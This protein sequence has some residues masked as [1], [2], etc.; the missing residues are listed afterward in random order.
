VTREKGSIV[1]GRQTSEPETPKAGNG[2][3]AVRPSDDQ[4]GIA[5]LYSA[6]RDLLAA[7]WRE[8]MYA[9]K[10]GTE[11]EIIEMG[12]TGIHKVAWCSFG[13]KPLDSCG[14]FFGGAEGYPS[15]PVLYRLINK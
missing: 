4:S 14:C 7:G 8:A 13:H 3:Y 6:Y 12:S 1:P 11:I 10:D 2:E 5:R 15:H 9:P